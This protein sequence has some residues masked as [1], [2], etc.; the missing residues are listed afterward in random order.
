MHEFVL[1][2]DK[3]KAETGVSALDIAKGLIDDGI[4]P[5][6]MYFPLIV[7]EALMFE[8]TET[9]SKATLDFTAEVMEKLKKE[10]YSDAAKVHEYPYTKPINR[11]DETK[12]ARE[13]VLRYK[14][15]CCCK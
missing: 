4:H 7:H 2:L 9:E 3:I 12:A 6:T 8:P 11:V 1:T 15:C 14:P 13:P 5:P 10:A